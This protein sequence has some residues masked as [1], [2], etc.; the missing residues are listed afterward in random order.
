MPEATDEKEEDTKVY[1]LSEC[2]IAIIEKLGY[3]EKQTLGQLLK[4]FGYGA[5]VTLSLIGL[6]EKK[7]ATGP[8]DKKGY[9]LTNRGQEIFQ[10]IRKPKVS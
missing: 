2:D 4:S 3:E 6:K 9:S 8:D 1:G 7:I 10:N 5:E